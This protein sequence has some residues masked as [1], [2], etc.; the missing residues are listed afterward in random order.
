MLYLHTDYNSTV[1]VV[2]DSLS[3]IVMIFFDRISSYLAQTLF[4]LNSLDKLVGQKSL[5]TTLLNRFP[6]KL[7][8]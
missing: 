2:S 5:T 1:F 4:S 7:S 3:T 8:F 6:L